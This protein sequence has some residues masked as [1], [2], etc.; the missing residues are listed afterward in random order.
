ILFTIIGAR[1]TYQNASLVLILINVGLYLIAEVLVCAIVTKKVLLS[2]SDKWWPG[3][4]WGGGVLA[5]G[6]ATLFWKLSQTDGLI[7]RPD[8]FFQA[9]GMLWHPLAGVMA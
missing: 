3:V 8:S 5:I 1:W 4:V 7:C 9:H 2:S 6:F